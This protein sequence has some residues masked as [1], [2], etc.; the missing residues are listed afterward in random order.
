MGCVVY[1]LWRGVRRMYY[2]GGDEGNGM[3]HYREDGWMAG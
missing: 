2:Y 3:Y 1:F